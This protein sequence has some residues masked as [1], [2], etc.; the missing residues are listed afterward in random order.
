MLLLSTVF[1]NIDGRKKLCFCFKILSAVFIMPAPSSRVSGAERCDGQNT[2]YPSISKVFLRFAVFFDWRRVRQKHQH[3]RVE[4]VARKHYAVA[5]RQETQAAF[6]VSRRLENF[7]LL[8]P[9]S[10]VNPSQ[11]G[12]S[13]GSF[14]TF[15]MTASLNFMH[16]KT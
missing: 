11:I 15:F 1:M 3:K 8:S 6:R 2:S 5:P 7:N 16:L 12:I 10:N 4:R 13:S 14:S 9:R